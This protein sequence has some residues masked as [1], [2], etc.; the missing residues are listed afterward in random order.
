M[1]L[2][3]DGGRLLVF[4][5][6]LLL[7]A[8]IETRFPARPWQESRMKRAFFHGMV[9]ALNTVIIRLFIY[10]PFLLWVV[11]IEEQGWGISRWL[12]LDGWLE[13][14]LSLL[15]LDLFDYIWHRINHRFSFLWRFHKAHHAD[16][17]VDVTT[18]LRFHPGELILSS[19]SKAIWVVIW[20]PTPIAWFLFEGLISLCAQFHHSNTDLPDA[21]E[22]RV[23]RL[24]VTPRF[25]ASHHRVDPQYG[26]AN[27]STIFSFWDPL[28][29]S[30]SL[31]PTAPYGQ[32]P[33]EVIGL[34]EA[35]DRSLSFA[36]WLTEPFSQRNRGSSSQ[37]GL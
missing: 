21:I 33:P 1:E 5:G 35:R 36:A 29:R 18:A 3:L 15:V 7:F 26:D 32:L 27:Y 25:H 14:I 4:V 22:K 2:D 6:G 24:I 8:A 23:S 28:F 16:N 13:I 12:G 17:E 11:Y 9:A 30:Y 20:G 19:L 31:A 10:V 37:K 34:A